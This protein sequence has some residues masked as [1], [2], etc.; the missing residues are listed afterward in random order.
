MLLTVISD[1]SGRIRA[2][3]V[4]AAYFDDDPST[5]V[6]VTIDGKLVE[7]DGKPTTEVL[8]TNYVEA[9]WLDQLDRQQ[10]ADRLTHIRT[11]MRI[12]IH[13]DGCATLEEQ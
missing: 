6:K 7:Q 12:A 13:K 8:Q 5:P 9:A 11:N 10:L 2:L 4:N 3:A 1:K